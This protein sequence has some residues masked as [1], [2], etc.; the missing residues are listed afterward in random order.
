MTNDILTVL[1][2]FFITNIIVLSANN[3]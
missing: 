3:N 1:I 2:K